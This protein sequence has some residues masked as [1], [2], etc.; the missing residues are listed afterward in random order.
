ML[1]NICQTLYP[2]IKIVPCKLEKS[3]FL[4]ILVVVSM[5][6]QNVKNCKVI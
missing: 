1:F 3:V 6:E 2:I 5:F 4:R